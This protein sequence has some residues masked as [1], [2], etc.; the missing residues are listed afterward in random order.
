MLTYMCPTFDLLFGCVCVPPGPSW[1]PICVGVADDPGVHQLFCMGVAGELLSQLF[2]HMAT[3]AAYCLT[4]LV[5]ASTYFWTYVWP[6]YAACAEAI[7]CPIC[8]LPCTFRRFRGPAWSAT[9]Q[10]P[11]PAQNSGAIHTEVFWGVH[12]GSDKCAR[13]PL[14]WPKFGRGRASLGSNSSQIWSTP[15]QVCKFGQVWP[16]QG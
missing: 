4:S 7:L 13:S 14:G 11:A 5:P 2:F 10:G 12:R 8:G 16:M 3:L 1:R 6:I 15:G 9:L